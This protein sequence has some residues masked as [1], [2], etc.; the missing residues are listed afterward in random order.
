MPLAGIGADISASV[1]AR[2]SDAIAPSGYVGELRVV[3]P[4][5]N[6][7]YGLLA[8]GQLESQPIVVPF[9]GVEW[10]SGLNGSP[11]PTNS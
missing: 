1:D 3:R 7:S 9:I 8:L 4:G 10:L 2:F 11:A 5:L 6:Y